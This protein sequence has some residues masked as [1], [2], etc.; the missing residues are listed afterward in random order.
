MSVSLG[1]SIHSIQAA[2]DPNSFSKLCSSHVFL[3]ILY[4][5][6]HYHLP[7]LHNSLISIT[8]STWFKNPMICS[9][10]NLLS[11][12]PFIFL[13]EEVHKLFVVNVSLG[14]FIFIFFDLYLIHYHF[15]GYYEH[16]TFTLIFF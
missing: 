14:Y 10:I 4:K 12:L 7:L 11:F 9:W 2:Y 1:S 3:I 13:R 15:F 5:F 6:Y 8:V 16:S